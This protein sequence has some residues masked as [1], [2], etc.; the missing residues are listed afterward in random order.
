[1]TMIIIKMKDGSTR[2][3]KPSSDGPNR[4]TGDAFKLVEALTNSDTRGGVKNYISF[5]TI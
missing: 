3:I 5:E 1:M 2:T 4:F